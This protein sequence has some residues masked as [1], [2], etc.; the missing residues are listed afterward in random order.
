MLDDEYHALRT[1]AGV[2][3]LDDRALVRASG[4]DRVAF[5][6]GM[7]TNDVTRLGPGDGCPALLLT[8]QGRVVSDLRVAATA[9][10]LLLDV[11]RGARDAVIESLARLIIA[12]DVELDVV[13]DV[14]LLGLAGPDT[15]RLAPGLDALPPFAHRE[16][17]IA[18]VALRLVHA[19]AVGGEGAILHAPAARAGDVRDALAAAG[20]VFCG[21][22]ALEA[23]RIERGIPRTGVD[24]GEKTLALEVP[25]EAAISTTKGCYLGQE[26][27][28]RGT[29][30]GHVNRRLCGL[31]FAGGTPAADARLVHD[32]REV[33]QVTSVAYSPALAAPVG[34]GFVR[35]EHWEPGTELA[36]VDV[37]GAAAGTARVAAWPLA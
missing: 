12:D 8:I 34:L 3:V 28:A 35:R 1:H 2:F 23:R 6:Q 10:A 4:A 25:V 32:G 5:L 29:A 20:A 17:T 36:V 26:V 19:S 37:A 21:R 18:G 7:L 31:V 13:D 22:A 15:P 16:T 11:D 14:T 30:R 27:I 24:M 33:G 9:D